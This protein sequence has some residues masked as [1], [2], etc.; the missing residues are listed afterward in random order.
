ME[1]FRQK[2][3]ILDAFIDAYQKSFIH[4]CIGWC[5][6]LKTIQLRSEKIELMRDYLALSLRMVMKLTLKVQTLV[7]Y[8]Q[9]SP[10]SQMPF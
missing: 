3:D 6:R 1:S 2:E 9:R 4:L 10:F 7:I 5:H 8:E